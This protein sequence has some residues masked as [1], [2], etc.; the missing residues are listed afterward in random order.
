MYYLFIFNVIFTLLAGVKVPSTSNKQ[1]VS[2]YLR[3]AQSELAIFP[4]NYFF[5]FIFIIQ[6]NKFLKYKFFFFFKKKKKRNRKIYLF[7]IFML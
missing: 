4:F 1:M 6:M 3:S 7:I 2:G 5:I